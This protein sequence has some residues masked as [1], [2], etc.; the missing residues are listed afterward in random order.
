MSLGINRPN[1]NTV[2]ATKSTKKCQFPNWIQWIRIRL[3]LIKQNSFDFVLNQRLI[4]NDHGDDD[5]SRSF[6]FARSSLRSVRLNIKKSR[7]NRKSSKNRFFLIV[8]CYFISISFLL[9]SHFSMSRLQDKYVYA[10]DIKHKCEHNENK[11]DLFIQQTSLS[12]IGQKKKER[13][14][15]RERERKK[16]AI[17][18]FVLSTDAGRSQKRS[19]KKEREREK[20][21]L[22]IYIYIC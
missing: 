3:F 15:P 2:Y 4:F 8:L 18:S 9:S 19:G 12:L 16:N 5:N 21:S 7:M 17:C 14:R 1:K 20:N 22:C 11:W 13:E 6:R 10:I